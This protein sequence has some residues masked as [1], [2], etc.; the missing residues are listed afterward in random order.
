MERALYPDTLLAYAMNGE[1]LPV[2]HGFP[3]RLLVP[4][5]YGMASVKWLSAIHAIDEHFR[6]YFQEER[7]VMRGGPVPDGTPVTEIGVR[8][9]IT[10]PEDRARVKPGLHM[11]RGF[12]WSGAAPVSEIEVC[13]DGSTWQPAAWTSSSERYAWR[14]WEY[15]WH[16]NTAGRHTLRSRT[17]DEAGNLQPEQGIWNSLGYANNAIQT[18]YVTVE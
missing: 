1:V 14:C 6:G 13:T 7:Y 9:I 3:V 4:G 16:A 18:V 2:A 12:A 11:V 10:T 8:S 17:R 5:W 15:A